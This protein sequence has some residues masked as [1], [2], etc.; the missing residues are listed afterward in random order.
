MVYIQENGVSVEEDPD[1]NGIWIN[2]SQMDD[3]Y[4]FDADES[5][6]LLRG[7]LRRELETDSDPNLVFRGALNELERGRGSR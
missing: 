7:L 4:W 1:G 2:D 5:E 6:V 3:V